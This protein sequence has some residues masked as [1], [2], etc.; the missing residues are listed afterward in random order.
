MSAGLLQS[1]VLDDFMPAPV[2]WHEARRPLP[3]LAF[4]LPFV[5]A[6][7]V[8]MS[9]TG[10]TPETLRNGADCWMRSWIL[11]LGLP[12]SWIL[13]SLLITGLLAWQMLGS[14]PWRVSCDTLTGMFGESL[15]FAIVLVVGGQS[16]NVLFRSHGFE[17]LAVATAGG[18]G[19]P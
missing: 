3:T 2:Y 9:W 14:Y 4:V 17:T 18:A 16:L 6:Y 15:L 19:E 8:G 13:P 11:D 12:S 5:L 7:E 10:T 1:T